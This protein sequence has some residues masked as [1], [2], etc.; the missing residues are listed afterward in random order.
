MLLLLLLLLPLPLLLGKGRTPA[1]TQH[2]YK[3]AIAACRARSGVDLPDYS[4]RVERAVETLRRMGTEPDPEVMCRVGMACVYGKKWERA[5]AIFEDSVRRTSR[6]IFGC[7]C[8]GGVINL[9]TRH[10]L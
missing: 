6:P 4:E 9:L 10:P 8:G 1:A 5:A 2:T 3:L 7:V